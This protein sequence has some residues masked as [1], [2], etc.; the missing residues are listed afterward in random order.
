M[1][2]GKFQ[3]W[4]LCYAGLGSVAEAMEMMILSF[5]GP[6]LESEWGL[7]STQETLITTVVFAGMLVGAYSWGVISDNF[8]RR[9]ETFFLFSPKILGPN[10]LS[11]I[12]SRE[13]VSIYIYLFKRMCILLW[14]SLSLM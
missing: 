6:A 13:Y 12:F 1:G 7:S 4:V 2:F 10:S 14:K 5:I 9:Q 3:A 11:F 8:G